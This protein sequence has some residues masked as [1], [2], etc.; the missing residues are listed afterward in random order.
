MVEPSPAA[1]EPGTHWQ[2]ERVGYFMVDP[3]DSRS[4]ALVL[5]RTVTLRDSWHGADSPAPDVAR[6]QS[7]KARTRPAK[8]SR[9]V[10]GRGPA[11]R[12]GAG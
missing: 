8:K 7:A 11:A 12:P 6:E 4:G 9:R 1:S 10:P 2:L 3:V 5:N